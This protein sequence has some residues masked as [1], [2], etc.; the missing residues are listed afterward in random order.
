MSNFRFNLTFMRG[1]SIGAVFTSA[2]SFVFLVTFMLVDSTQGAQGRA[3]YF[4]AQAASILSGKLAVPDRLLQ[5]ECFYLPTDPPGF[6][7]GYFGIFPSIVRIPA[8]LLFKAANV[9]QATRGEIYPSNSVAASSQ[10]A[11]GAS[12]SINL[13]AWLIALGTFTVAAFLITKLMVARVAIFPTQKANGDSR[14]RFIWG[15][16]IS[17]CVLSPSLL[18]TARPLLY[19]EAIL[20]GIS[21]GLLSIYFVIRAWDSSMRYR[22][23]ILAGGFAFLAG[24]CR[25]TSGIATVIALILTIFVSTIRAL[26]LRARDEYKVLLKKLAPIAVGLGLAISGIFATT[27]IKFHSFVQ[28]WEFHKEIGD[29]AVRLDLLRQGSFSVLLLPSKVLALLKFDV[30]SWLDWNRII[31]VRD[32]NFIFLWPTS[33]NDFDYGTVPVPKFE[34]TAIIEL[35]PALSVLVVFSLFQ[36]RAFSKLISHPWILTTAFIT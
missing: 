25:P 1:W 13:M 10:A 17:S 5:G 21:F 31:T 23:F 7:T 9:W 15:F 36:F 20:W 35:I 18:L 28:P 12:I 11:F 27:L 33:I 14:L 16:L 3:N 22:Y 4:T 29:S 8:L 2:M 32:S 6:C 26:P 30:A 19:E 24:I 34:S